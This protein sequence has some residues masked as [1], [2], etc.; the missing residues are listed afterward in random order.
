MTTNRLHDDTHLIEKLVRHYQRTVDSFDW[1]IWIQCFA[2][3]GIF[4]TPNLFGMMV[5]RDEIYSTCKN[6]VDSA[7]ELLQ[8][9]IT[10]LDI[11]IL[12]GENALAYADLILV[13][14]PDKLSPESYDMSGGRYKFVFKKINS[15][16]KIL[17]IDLDILWKKS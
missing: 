4:N 6:N 5:G 12:D 14:V 9:H 1:D 11:E 3:D 16:W 8:H 2:E 13:G 10:N 17:R 15:V 7:Y